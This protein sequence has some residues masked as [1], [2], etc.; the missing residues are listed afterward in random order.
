MIVVI[1]AIILH[2]AADINPPL[3]RSYLHN[4]T[5]WWKDTLV[6]STLHS[7][8]QCNASLLTPLGHEAHA[9]FL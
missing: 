5:G 1:S 9:F 4:E 2:F 6:P 7:R 3:N 8:E